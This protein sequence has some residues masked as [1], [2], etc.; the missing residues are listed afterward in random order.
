MRKLF[1]LIRNAEWKRLMGY[2]ALF[3]A[4]FL[5]FL[6]LTFPFDAVRD[7][8]INK[9]ESQG[10]LSVKIDEISTFRLS[11]LQIKGL[12]LAHADS[13]TQGWCSLDEARMRLR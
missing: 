13:P 7:T 2:G 9:I 8:L 11:G 3:S 12:Q 5:L 1:N 4:L 10:N 6:Y